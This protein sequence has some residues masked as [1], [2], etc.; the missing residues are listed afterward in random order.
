MESG[1]GGQAGALADGTGAAGEAAFGAAIKTGWR[2]DM[3]FASRDV[4][5]IVKGAHRACCRA[6]LACT[7][8]AGLFLRG[9]L[10]FGTPADCSAKGHKKPSLIVYKEVDW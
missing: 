4:V 7:C 3:G 6:G 10:H 9:F 1:L 8:Q 2:C 5:A